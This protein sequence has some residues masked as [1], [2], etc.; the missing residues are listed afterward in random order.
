MRNVSFVGIS[1]TVTID[2]EGD[3]IADYS[4]LD[5]TDPD[6]GLFEVLISQAITMS[7]RNLVLLKLISIQAVLRYY[8]ATKEYVN[9]RSIHWPNGKKPVDV[10][11]CGFDGSRCPGLLLSSL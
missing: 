8:G 3:R 4:L 1:G 11:P 9:L 5:Q 10:P 7:R 2:A 6:R